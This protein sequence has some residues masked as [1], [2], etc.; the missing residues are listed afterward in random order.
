MSGTLVGI[1]LCAQA[2]E[3][4]ES[5]ET[6]TALAGRGLAG[7]RYAEAVGTFS[8]WP[9]KGR[10]LTLIEAEA[11]ESL[12]RERGVALAPHESRRNL[13]VRDLRL[14]D[15]LGVRFRLGEVVLV[16]RRT[17]PPC[18]HLE[19]LT[20]PGVLKALVG[21]GGLRAD[22]E[23]GGELRVGETLEILGPAP[24]GPDESSCAGES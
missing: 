16:G 7:D 15:L 13:V 6:A 11:L 5:R 14:E 20:R 8:S 2:G 17:A 18:E 9:G 12:E 22:I 1:Y 10:A 21:R 24:V 4:M 19:Q 23:V 3:P